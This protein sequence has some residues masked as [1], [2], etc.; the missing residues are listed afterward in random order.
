MFP[1][2][3]VIM[4]TEI[5]SFFIRPCSLGLRLFCNIFSKELFLGILAALLLQFFLKGTMVDY[6]FSGALLVMRPAIMLMGLIIAFIQALVFMILSMSYIA[7]A[8]HMEEH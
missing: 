1:V 3:L 8:V 7:G 4:L 6:L 2:A 5:I